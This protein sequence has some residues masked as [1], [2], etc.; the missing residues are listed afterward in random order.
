MK[1]LLL[2]TLVLALGLFSLFAVDY[3]IRE[4]R[5]SFTIGNNAVHHVEETISVNFEGPHHGIVR[6]IPVDYREY[7]GKTV[8]K[9]SNLKCSADYSTSYDNGY[10]VMQIGDANKTV[11]GRV[12]YTISYDYDLGA[13][14]NDGYDELY[15]NLIGP[16]WECPI[17]FAV[18]SVR[19][20]YVPQEQWRDYE[21][22]IDHVLD[23]TY[24]TSGPY[25]STRFN[26]DKGEV[27]L[28]EDDDGSLLIDGYMEDMGPYE[29]ITIRIDL[30]E[31]WYVGARVP[32]DYTEIA[33]K[34]NPIVCIILIALAMLI[35]IRYGRDN[36]PIVVARF[37]P[38]KGF[39]PLMVGY[40]AD[41][42]V[43]DK[44]VISMIFYW[45]DEGLLKIEEKKNG[46]FEFTKLKDIEAYAIESG[47]DIPA[48]EVKLFNGF[49]HCN[50]DEKVTFKDLEKNKFYETIIETKSSTKN[51][52]K[53]ERALKDSN[54]RKKAGL[55]SLLSFI[56]MLLLTVT[57]ALYENV[58]TFLALFH[59]G[60]GFALF[61]MNLMSFDSLFK[62]WHMRKTKILP[63]VIRFV[64]PV[65]AVFVLGFLESIIREANPDFIQLIFS[66]SCCT[67]M[68]LFG[69]VTDKR[70]KYGDEVLEG[71]L[72]YR[73]FID[74]V[75][76]DQLKMMIESDPDFYYKVLS[77]AV[78]LGLEDKWAKKFKDIPIQ[79]PDWL[80]GATV[81]DAY[82]WARLARR[83]NTSIP[84]ASMPKSS[85]SGSAGSHAGGGGFHSSGFSGGGFGG[86]G[87]HAW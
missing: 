19:L 59:L 73:E 12:D 32:W 15:L 43:D 2:I 40:V 82:Y 1:K 18:F 79:Q 86:G 71:I 38:P 48:F 55:V 66:V 6:E 27:Y 36:I 53:G 7:N 21:A 14:F 22:F 13:D 33:K 56:P 26:W 17:E 45:A 52:F 54:S 75:E 20:P 61:I 74:K 39:S 29:G 3:S 46:K 64:I 57:V 44:D 50:V 4:Y 62:T 63:S 31:G 65:L 47:K 69:A 37:Q 16:H 58:D 8:A 9:I 72:G 80:T 42:T 67:L 76:I 41:S 68:A 83:M 10:M 51:F 35:W 70:T 84:A 34:I 25:G 49:F 77:Y 85:I 30:P 87:G 78:V 24:M 81:L 28:N 5:I 23:N 60:V 11:I